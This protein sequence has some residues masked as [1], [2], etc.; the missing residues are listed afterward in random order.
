MAVKKYNTE[1]AKEVMKKVT[2]MLG[3]GADNIPVEKG[4]FLVMFTD[5]V[6]N[7]YGEQY[8]Y[9]SIM[10]AANRKFEYDLRLYNKPISIVWFIDLLKSNPKGK[11]LSVVL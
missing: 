2:V 11:R 3:I 7:V 10:D 6:L 4:L 5:A 9:D 1:E 8:I